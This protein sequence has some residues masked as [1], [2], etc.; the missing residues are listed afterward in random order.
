MNRPNASALLPALL[1]TLAL[2]AGLVPQAQAQAQAQAQSSPGCATVE[3]RN[4][5]PQQG[6][7]M[8]A[9][10][11]SAE[12]FGRQPLRAVTVPAGDAVTRL[13]L[14]GLAGREVALM[15]YQDLDGNGRMDRNLLGMPLEPWGSSGTPGPM[16]PVWE[17]GRVP[18]DGTTI[19]VRMSV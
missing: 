16:G 3:V 5:R 1:C 8:V 14:C 7:L 17:S 6:V 11:V 4:V 19:V 12:S 18:L 15:L 2:A 13:E 10:Y 9:A